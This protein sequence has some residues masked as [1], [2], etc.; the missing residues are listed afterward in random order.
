MAARPYRNLR[1]DEL[2]RLFTKSQDDEACLRVILG[3]LKHRIILGELNRRTTAQAIDLRKRL[4]K[5][6]KIALPPAISSASAV[7]PQPPDTTKPAQLD[8]LQS[9]AAAAAS[10]TAAAVRGSKAPAIQQRT[11]PPPLPR[12]RPEPER[13]AASPDRMPRAA[14]AAAA[15]P[16]AGK[17]ELS[18]IQ[19]GVTQLIDYVRVL[20]ELSDKPVW[21]LGSYGDVVLREDQLRNRVGIR[22]D[23]ADADGPIYLKVDRL[24]RIDP[25]D[26]PALA[27][28]WLTA[29]RDPFI[30]PKVQRIRT[31][32]MPA[33]DIA[34]LVCTGRI[35]AADATP[36]LKPRPGEDLRDVILRLERFPRAKAAVEEY[37][38]KAWAGWAQAERPRRETIDIYDRLFSLQQALKLEGSDRPLEVVWGIGVARWQRPPNELDHPIVEQLVELELNDEGAIQV[39]PRGVDPLLALK[40]FAAMNNPG[41]DLVARFARE[42]FA[43]LPPERELSPFEPDTFTPILRY[44]CAQLDRGGRYY[45]DQ[46]SRDDRTIPPAGPNLVVTDTWAIYARP[47]SDNFFVADL[48][49][50][51]EAVE[52]AAKPLPGPAVALVTEPADESTYTPAV[53]GIARLFGGPSGQSS[54]PS[55]DDITA[56][57]GK[58][59]VRRFFFPKPYN[60]EQ[61]A[62]VD[63]LESSDVEGVVVQGPPG[64]GKTHTIANIICHYLAT[65]RRVLVTSKSEGALAVLRDHIPEGIRDLAISLLTSERQGLKQLEATVNILAS[66]IASLDARPIERD[67]ADSERRIAELERRIAAADAELCSFA[68]K[69][70]R[71]FPAAGQPDGILPSELAERI[72]GECDRYDWFTDR[73]GLSDSQTFKFNDTD[74]AAARN[75]RKALGA[76]LDYLAATL[77][78]ISDL[79]DAAT[80]ASIH[81]DLAN[82]A[83]I[84]RGRASD[85]PVMSSSEAD[86][87]R[88]AE[89][90]LAAVDALVAAHEHC[91][92]APWLGEIFGLW[93][94]HGLDAES[95]R[96]FAQLVATLS[97]PIRRRMTIASY[98]VA[99]PDGAHARI[100]LVAAVERASAGQRPF[101]LMPFGKSEVRA[102][103]GNIRILD[104]P[105]ADPS[106]WRQI[107][108]VLAWRNDVAGALA[109]WRALAAEFALPPLPDHLDDAARLLQAVLERVTSVA[110]SVRRHIPIIQ[111]E[112]SRLFPYGLNAAEIA[113]SLEQAR[114]ASEAIRTELSHHRF[115][116]ARAKLSAATEKLASC[117]G[118][119]SR[120]IAAFL[121]A[122][123]GDPDKPASA[124]AEQWTALLAEL[125]RMRSL[126]AH[127]D[128]VERVAAAVAESGAPNWARSLCVQP[129]EGIEDSWTP[130]DWHDA[131]IWAQADAYLRTIDGR[132]R[133]R[134]LDH[135]RRA[136]DE[137]RRR[138]LHEVV[139]LRTLL[140]LKARITRRIDA[141]LQMFLTAIRRIGRGTGKSASRLRRD[142]RDAMET[143]YS[144]VPCWIMPSWRISESLPATLGSFDLVIFDEASQSDI[145]AL[146]ALLRAKKALIVGDDKQVSPTAAFIEEQRLRSL[147]MHH[148]DGQPF[149][150]LLLPGNSLYELALACY[151]GRRIMLKEHFRCVE[152]IIRFSFQFYTEEIVPVRV[153]KASERLSPPLIDVHVVEGRKDRSNRNF[154]E[155]EAIVDE[156]ARIVA[157]PAMASRTIGVISLIGAKQ[158]QLIQ[159]M[160]LERIGE[161]AFVRHD[162][163][164]GDSAVFQGKERDIVL[165]SMVECPQTCTSKTALPFQQRFNVALSRARDREYLFRSVTEEMLKP[166]DLKAKVLRH[167]KNPML[168]RT[169][170]AADL[171]SLCQSGFERDVLARLLALGYRV[172]PQI[173]VGPFSIDL[174]VEG[175]DDR[176]LAVELDGDRYH[177]PERWADDLA[178]QRVME[179]VGWRFW[180]CWGS[181][182]RLD[183]DGCMDDLVRALS[184]L[185]IEPI[186]DDEA[187]TVWT[188]FRTTAP[189]PAPKEAGE[190]IAA[191]ITPAVDTVLGRITATQKA[192]PAA[193]VE[194]GNIV[195][196]GDR[197]QVQIG[198]E[199]RV[200]VVTLTDDRNDSDLGI[201]SVRHPAG[202]ALLGA[203]ED[204]EIE[205]EIDNQ[206]RHWMVM[207]IEKGQAIASV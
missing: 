179:R 80:L 117:S 172:Q 36:T 58:D 84:E 105:P 41:T 167:F 32:V 1:I 121:S 191:E 27:R 23:L 141:A 60:E 199:A 197:V 170:A 193:A 68:E 206:P 203:Q 122:S 76:D 49:R 207:K 103:F 37:I 48:E 71:P 24:E 19:C 171:M 194:N 150:A 153:P 9:G 61:I 158:A 163:A 78:S 50:L 183:P 104:R 140:T 87:L 39:R 96:P 139:R 15:H 98:G 90:L 200:R 94:R 127:L 35:D 190:L 124:I 7:R 45:P 40:P 154:A 195:E 198:E 12:Q 97:G 20:L 189:P 204:Q 95:V 118:H 74:V 5:H 147:R 59:A 182:F 100:E 51:R 111:A 88:R 119:I 156:I 134:E 133:L 128:T 46:A 81:Q 92:E 79:P 8:L 64:T 151:P 205:F 31:A 6:L 123:V 34:R 138:L 136:A 43:K 142:A 135:Q 66:Q 99:A 126:R 63:R 69:H 73:P 188:E 120:A 174:V 176:R 187:S 86:V 131:W 93:R 3:E 168:G 107:S 10:A 146:P 196:I 137:E 184:S 65:G 26:P 33:A 75:A 159:A 62:I 116:G 101:G 113:A 185:G 109:R 112:V 55:I 16:E 145:A 89:A 143:S 132:A 157:D 125:A 13:R 202:A 44:A 165:L 175:R 108:E 192:T 77:P 173:K 2:D 17:A 114:R 115:A 102:A 177:P 148:L 28:D 42:H 106:E 38:A 181:S 129:V 152:P 144:A 169:P 160:L 57:D 18:P 53:S 164:C 161:E 14:A 178:R 186:G 4:E 155:A 110:E 83:L 82:A 25:P 85:A 180:R 130:E 11:P 52:E 22:H 149:G 21:A 201:I 67:I 29:S 70:L 54:T 30:E 47:R 166:D 72:V 56:A 91:V 162:I